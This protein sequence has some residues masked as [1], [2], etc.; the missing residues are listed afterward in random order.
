MHR[1]LWATGA[2]LVVLSLLVALV[3]SAVDPLWAAEHVT[4]LAAGTWAQQAALVLGAALLAAGLVVVRLAPP[5]EARVDARR[6]G[7]SDWFA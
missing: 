6:D 4:L 5:A 2:G 1:V 3:L 7:S